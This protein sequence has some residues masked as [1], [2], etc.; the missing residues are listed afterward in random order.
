MFGS[1]KVKTVSSVVDSFTS[2]FSKIADA[3]QL[4]YDKAQAAKARAE[5]AMEEA[6]AEL[7]MANRAIE[8]IK[9]ML[10][11]SASS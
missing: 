9:G 1:K 11:C 5:L 3:Q 4:E 8:N 7:T 2:E 6:N 10:S